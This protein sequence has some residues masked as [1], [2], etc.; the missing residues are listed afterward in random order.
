MPARSM[1]QAASALGF[2]AGLEAQWTAA[3]GQLPGEAWMQQHRRDALARVRRDGL[4]G[5]RVE[6]WKYADLAGLCREALPLAGPEVLSAPAMGAPDLSDALRVTCAQGRVTG[7]PSGAS[8]PDD[9]EVL[10]LADALDVPS[11]WL[12]PWLQ[13]GDDAINNLNLAFA[14]DGVLLRVGREAK[15]LTLVIT[16]DR[17]LRGTMAHDRSVVAIEP[18]ARVTLV[19]IQAFRGTGAGLATSRLHVSLGEGA[20]LDHVRVTAGSDA[21]VAVQDD[22]VDLAAGARYRLVSLTDGAQL[23]RQQAVVA[24]GGEGAAC[25]MATAYEAMSQ[26]TADVSTEVRHL[27]PATSSRLLAKGLAGKQGRGVVQGRIVVDRLAQGTDSHQLARG[28]LLE[29]GAEVFHRPE[30][31]IHADDVKCGHGATTASLDANQLFYLQSR[32]IP[33]DVARRMLLD[34]YVNEVIERAP[35]ALHAFLEAWASGHRLEG[36]VS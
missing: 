1:A 25:E 21:V 36:G 4:P 8:I 35:P 9:V 13:P 6:W 19:E 14:T 18:G 24:L 16:Y 17:D 22:V 30:L 15:P 11:L 29:A 20:T 27:A 31:E 32:G 10:R 12:R 33:E 28:L 34:A 3:Q 26:R 2:E 23:L 5:R 7:L